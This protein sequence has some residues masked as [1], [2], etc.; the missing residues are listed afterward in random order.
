MSLAKR[1][2]TGLGLFVSLATGG[3]TGLGFFEIA[4]GIIGLLLLQKCH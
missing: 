4:G 1:R 3:I 2:I